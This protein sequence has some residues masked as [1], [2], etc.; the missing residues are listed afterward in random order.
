LYLL[1]KEKLKNGYLAL[2]LKLYRLE[3]WKVK[4]LGTGYDKP[5][6][7]KKNEKTKR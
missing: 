5:K 3:W 4:P 2:I 6:Y 1:E 7:H